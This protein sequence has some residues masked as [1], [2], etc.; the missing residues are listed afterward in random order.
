MK[1]K[2]TKTRNNLPEKRWA[3]RGSKPELEGY[4]EWS[5]VR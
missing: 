1:S 4:G 3:Q 5:E 2:T